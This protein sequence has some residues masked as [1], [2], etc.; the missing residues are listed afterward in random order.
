[1]YDSYFITN[2]VVSVSIKLV[3]SVA[4][5]SLLMKNY[6]WPYID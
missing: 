4:V 1:M 2:L 6:V 3:F 5:I